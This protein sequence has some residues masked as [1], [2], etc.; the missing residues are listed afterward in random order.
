MLYQTYQAHSD[1]AWP[2]HFAAR[3]CLGVLN[4]IKHLSASGVSPS[5][6]Q[7][8]LAAAYEVFSRARLT[9]VRP[10]FGIDQV[11]VGDREVEISEE[12]AFATPFAKLLHFRKAGTV[13]Q[14]RVL[15]V[16]PMSGHFAT[17]LRDTVRTMLPD[18]DVFITDWGNARD[19]PA[20]Y[21]AFGMNEYIAHLI[22]FLEAIGPGAHMIAVC[23]PCV[24][25]LAAAAVMAEGGHV[26][27]PRSITLMAGPIDCR[28]NPTRVNELATSRPMS[29]FES[30]LIAT[31]P[32]R[33]KGALR[34]VYPGF[35]QMSAFMSMNL[36][37]H[38][39]AFVDMYNNLVAGET[40][41]ADATGSFYRNISRSPIYRPSSISKPCVWCFRST[42][43]RAAS[44]V[45]KAERSTPARSAARR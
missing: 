19:V 34:R 20:L 13:A 8:R 18:H 41:K 16:A 4:Q 17:L 15:I 35:L 10:E 25:T 42:R 30:N 37:R 3:A 26:A 45:G 22:A 14:P 39:K 21:G 2:P 9:H 40:E 31:V 12:V 11:R 6:A 7:R 1:L 5:E 33:F 32:W 43:S 44:C 24:A 28:I 23:Q 29:W 38:Q 36:E 27:E